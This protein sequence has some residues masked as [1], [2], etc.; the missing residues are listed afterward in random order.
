MCMY[1]YI[2]GSN[3]SIQFSDLVIHDQAQNIM[4]VIPA[5]WSTTESMELIAVTTKP[6]PMMLNTL[7]ISCFL[8]YRALLKDIP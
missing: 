8:S 2:L 7:S 1:I 5:P 3:I 6:T 4:Y